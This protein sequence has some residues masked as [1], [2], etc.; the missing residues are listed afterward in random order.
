MFHGSYVLYLS[1]FIFNRPKTLHRASN[2]IP[3]LEENLK[4]KR[5]G[6]QNSGTLLFLNYSNL[7][8]KDL[9]KP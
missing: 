1:K 6:S 5:E 3:E 8:L 2:V 7:E 4:P 9:F